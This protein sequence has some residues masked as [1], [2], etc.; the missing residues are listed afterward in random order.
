MKHMRGNMELTLNIHLY[1]EVTYFQI[2]RRTTVRALRCGSA[3][4]WNNPNEES[5]PISFETKKKSWRNKKGLFN[6]RDRRFTSK[7]QTSNAKEGLLL[8]SNYSNLTKT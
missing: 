2:K 5:K 1:V 4:D 3:E 6:K 8:S 7:G